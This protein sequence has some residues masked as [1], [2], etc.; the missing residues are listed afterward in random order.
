MAIGGLVR[1]RLARA[2]EFDLEIVVEPMSALPSTRNVEE[3]I[4]GG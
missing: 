4:L 3:N 1:E 2:K